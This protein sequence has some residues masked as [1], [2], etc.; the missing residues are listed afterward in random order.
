MTIYI[1]NP[2]NISIESFNTDGSLHKRCYG[3]LTHRN[4]IKTKYFD[5]NGKSNRIIFG[6]ITGKNCKLDKSEVF[7][8]LSYKKLLQNLSI[9]K[10]ERH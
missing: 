5:L 8:A 6:Q 3:L 10:K 4:Q 9:A 1:N 7:L 2:I